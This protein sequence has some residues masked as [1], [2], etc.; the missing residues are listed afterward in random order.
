[1]NIL[2]ISLAAAR[3]NAKLTQ[4]DVAKI[5]GVSRQTI[6]NWENGKAKLSVADLHLLSHIY[7]IPVNNLKVDLRG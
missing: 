3:I 2:K 4:E 6:M 5:A 1:M 7:D